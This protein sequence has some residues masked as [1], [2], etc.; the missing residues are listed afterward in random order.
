MRTYSAR[1]LK[2]LTGIHP[3]LRRVIDRA[4]QSSPVDFVVIEGL[5]T[6][7]RQREL[8]A[9]GASK[10]MNSRHLTGHAVDLWPIDP[11]TGKAASARDERR[12]WALYRQLA[13]AVK[14]AAEAE[15]VALDWG[16]DWA[17]F[18]DG[19]HFELNR[20]AYPA[21][22][23]EAKP[24]TRSRTIAGAS[25]AAAGVTAQELAGQLQPLVGMSETVKTVFLCLTVAGLALVA[26]A[27]WDDHRRGR[28]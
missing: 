5:R 25:L 1:S 14:A 12:L 10:T 27:R 28:L 8:V 17:K 16:G 22:G 18:P 15:G 6:V 3:D 11:Q 13:P 2:S 4:L 7:E 19:P 26:Y 9:S 20:K 24:L 23:A 21:D